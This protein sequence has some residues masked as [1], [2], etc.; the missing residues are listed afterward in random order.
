VLSRGEAGD[1]RI[2]ASLGAFFRHNGNKAPT[3]A[4]CPGGAQATDLE[5]AAGQLEGTA[6]L[7]R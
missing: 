1:R 5:G 4:I 7:G 6:S 2:P 3:P